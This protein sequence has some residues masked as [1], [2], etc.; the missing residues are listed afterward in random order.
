MDGPQRMSW[1]GRNSR[2]RPPLLQLAGSA[3]HPAR[4]SDRQ[5]IP[6][7]SGCGVPHVA[8]RGRAFRYWIRGSKEEWPVLVQRMP[9]DSSGRRP[10]RFQVRDIIIP[11]A[12]HAARHRHGRV[13]S[14]GPSFAVAEPD[15]AISVETAARRRWDCVWG[16]MPISFGATR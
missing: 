10:H 5:R 7:P 13:G 3:L 1:P 9:P 11:L 2:G 14:W 8:R 4:W 6:V 15:P 16:A 12:Q